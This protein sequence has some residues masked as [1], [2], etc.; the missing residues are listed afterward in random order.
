MSRSARAALLAYA[1][2]AL[3]ASVGNNLRF[4]VGLP[5][6]LAS[7]AAG[8][9]AVAGDDDGRSR[10]LGLPHGA[11]AALAALGVLADPARPSP[12]WYQVGCRA[13]PALALVA[14]V[15][16]FTTAGERWRRR[17]LWAMVLGQAALVAATPLAV[18]T[19]EIDVWA[20]NQFCARELLHG[21]HP[22]SVAPPDIY[23]GGYDYGYHA[24]V[25]PYPPA[26]LLANVLP[27]ALLGDYRWL[28]VG[29]VLATVALLRAAGRRLG[30]APSTVDLLT[31]AFALQPRL[32]FL[33]AFGWTEPLLLA[34]LAAFV[35]FQARAPG[36]AAQAVAF[37]L[38][39]A[40]KQYALAPALLYP[41][42]RPR[43][44]SLAIGLA[45][46]AATVVP[47]L[48]WNWRATLDGVTWSLRMNAFRVDSLSLTAALAWATGIQAPRWLGPVAQLAAAA[49]AFLLARRRGVPRL[50]LAS[51][52]AL[53]ASFLLGLQ[54]FQNYYLMVEALYLFA[55]LALA[56]EER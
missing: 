54:A 45:A 3:G 28:L 55:A 9:I 26:V 39:P 22:Y 49:L 10:P 6:A 24:T 1:A 35:Y 29:C 31:V 21:V 12:L 14:W 36:G 38:L 16:L 34:A 33:V 25:V 44:R 13:L 50:L 17:A 47:L 20:Q 19:P 5:F 11:L 27:V 15:P 23:R 40:L 53:Q 51:A 8:F 56:G 43:L 30:A 37:L 7:L 2:M 52:I 42:I 46:A 48:V 18:R 32:P 4:A 41:S